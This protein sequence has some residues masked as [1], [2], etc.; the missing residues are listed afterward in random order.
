[1]AKLTRQRCTVTGCNRMLVDLAEASAHLDA[2]GH[3]TAA[4]TV[5]C[6]EDNRRERRRNRT[7]YHHKYQLAREERELEAFVVQT[8]EKDRVAAIEAMTPL[9]REQSKAADA[10]EIARMQEAHRY[11]VAGSLYEELERPFSSE[12]LGQWT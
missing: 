2:T 3:R 4:W 5:R 11:L 10:A 7:G 6:S 12:G 8:A 9:T 1:M